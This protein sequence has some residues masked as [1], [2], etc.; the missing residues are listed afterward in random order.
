M[1]NI[2]GERLKSLRKAA[3]ITQQELADRV[4]VHLQTVSKWERGITEPDMCMFGEIASALGVT[5]EELWGVPSAEESC[6]GV[7]DVAA[8]GRAILSERRRA[9]ESQSAL[10]QAL[11][12]SAGAVSKWERGVVCP[13]FETLLALAS[14]FG[15]AP[16]RLYYSAPCESAAEHA[17]GS[18]PSAPAQVNTRGNGGLKYIAALALVIIFAVAAA[19]IIWLVPSTQ[20]GIPPASADGSGQTDNADSD[21]DIQPP[22]ETPADDKPSDDT[23]PPQEEEPSGGDGEENA[24]GEETDGTPHVHTYEF[25]VTLPTC[26]EQGYTTYTCNACGDSY[27]DDYVPA[28]GHTEG[29]WEEISSATCES[30]GEEQLCCTVCG[31]LLESRSTDKLPHEYAPSITNPTCTEQGYTTYTCTACGD[32]YIDDYVPANGHTEGEWFRYSAPTCTQEGE[33]RLCCN[34]C[35]EVLGKT[36]VEKNEHDYTLTVVQPSGGEQGYSLHTCTQCGYSYK[37]NFFTEVYTEGL[38]YEDTDGRLTVTGAGDYDG[39]EIVIPSRI[40]GTPVTAVGEGAFENCENITAITIPDTVTYIGSRAFAGT[41]IA[42]IAI[43]SSVSEI[44]GQIFSGCGNLT[45]VAYNCDYGPSESGVFFNI[46]SLEK[47]SFGGTRVPGYICLNSVNLCEVVLGDSVT[48]IG[49][50]AFSGCMNLKEINIPAKVS[51]IGAEAFS[52]SGLTSVSLPAAMTVIAERTFI[53]CT[54][55]KEVDIPYGVSSIGYMAFYRCSSL[56]SVTIPDSVMSIADE[57]F[58]GCSSIEYVKLPQYITRI[59]YSTFSGCVSLKD[60]NIPEGVAA[61]D[62]LAFLDCRSLE[63]IELPESLKSIAGNAFNGCRSLTSV[64]IPEGVKYIA[65]SVFINCD[66]LSEVIFADPSGWRAGDEI[67]AESAL[68]D[69]ETAAD[70]LKNKYVSYDWKKSE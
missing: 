66:N 38:E 27:I 31:V 49:Y 45:E 64:T 55:L 29:E 24:G 50:R 33:M 23:Q 69:G 36:A 14:H 17:E 15:V 3:D 62:G 47:V 54:Y 28:N 41:S 20:S 63:D 4:G 9:G 18:L 51:V 52:G 7:F 16:S 59:G 10:A 12:V 30:E 21:T 58:C 43:P 26:T 6:G 60:V 40:D 34:V 25:T 61:I 19:L 39:D 53:N 13:D 70:F 22:D 42:Y 44:G 37:D 8:L 2:F 68:S 11:G 35:G 48:E 46:P 57:A 32:S 65:D 67:L 1:G 56:V 5:I